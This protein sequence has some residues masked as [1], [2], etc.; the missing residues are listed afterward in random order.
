M[1]HSMPNR[2]QTP[3]RRPT[4]PPWTRQVYSRPIHF[5]PAIK[6]RLPPQRGLV[7]RSQR[8]RHRRLIQSFYS[9]LFLSNSET[10]QSSHS[11]KGKNPRSNRVHV[12]QIRIK[13][14]TKTVKLLVKS[15]TTSFKISSLQISRRLKERDL[16]SPTS[17]WDT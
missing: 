12:V 17:P 11:Q 7:K 15:S 10:A 14:S 2:K 1:R 4:T 8:P 3:M 9:N 13:N 6:M 5:S 16:S